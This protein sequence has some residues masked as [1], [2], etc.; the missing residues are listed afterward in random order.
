MGKNI[1]PPYNAIHKWNKDLDTDDTEIKMQTKC[2]QICTIIQ[3]TV[4]SL[5]FKFKQG[6][7]PYN[8]TL[9]KMCILETEYC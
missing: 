5:Y 1:T 6:V 3:V 4:R 8:Y 2:E 9:Y 7:L